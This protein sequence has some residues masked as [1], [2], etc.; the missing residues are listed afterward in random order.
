MEFIR[1]WLLGKNLCRISSLRRCCLQRRVYEYT[2]GETRVKF[3][4]NTNVFKINE[5]TRL[6]PIPEAP[7][8]LEEKALENN[9]EI[10]TEHGEK[11][12][13]NEAETIWTSE[14]QMMP[15]KL[16]QKKLLLLLMNFID[17]MQKM[18]S[19]LMFMEKK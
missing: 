17:M 18:K 6:L 16:K 1:I 2:V 5:Q 7:V 15:E 14:K 12:T 9:G 19:I 10:V 11:W 3:D 13:Y 4:P 8:G